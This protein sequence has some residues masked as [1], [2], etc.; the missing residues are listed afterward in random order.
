MTVSA[1]NRVAYSTRDAVAEILVDRPDKLNALDRAT[2]EQIDAAL[3]MAADD[4]AVRVVLIGGTG[5]KAFVAGADIEEMSMLRPEQAQAFSRYLQSVLDRIERFPKPIVARIQGFALGGGCE[6]ACACHLRVASTR[7]KFGQPEVNLGL[8]PGA[9]GTQRLTRLV[10]RGRALDLILTGRL[11]DAE[12]AHRIGLVD[13]LA[14]PDALEAEVEAL[15]ELLS[16]KSPVAQSRALEAVI[17][18]GELPLTEG[19]RLEAALFGLGFATEDMKEGTRAFL[20]KRKA[21]F[22]GR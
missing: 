11:M 16:S 5:D 6:L 9:G 3:T 8:I 13:R 12:E 1:F 2:M 22:E 17:A 20:E 4:G 7:A 14:E 18:G 10:G 15:I 21:R 19:L